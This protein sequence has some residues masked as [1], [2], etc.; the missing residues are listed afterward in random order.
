LVAEPGDPDAEAL[1]QAALRV[2]DPRVSLERSKPGERYPGLG[3]A[4]VYLCSDIACSR[5]LT[6]PNALVEQAEQ[7][8]LTR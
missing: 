3:H 7:F 6:D 4:A 1:E 5:P 8:L 2:W